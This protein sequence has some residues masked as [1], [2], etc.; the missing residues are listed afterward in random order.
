MFYAVRDLSHF[1][2]QCP[3]WEACSRSF[4]Q[5]SFLFYITQKFITAFKTFCKWCISCILPYYFIASI[6]LLPSTPWSSKSALSFRIIFQRCLRISNLLSCVTCHLY[7]IILEFLL[8][9]VSP[10]GSRAQTFWDFD[11][12]FSHT[13]LGR[14]PLDEWWTLRRYV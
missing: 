11:I 12:T 5:K 7:L 9:L 1:I 4:S 13:T 10:T 6:I 14:P 2:V 8:W 3:S